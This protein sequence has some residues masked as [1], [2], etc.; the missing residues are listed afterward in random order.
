MKNVLIILL[1]LLAATVLKGQ[2]STRFTNSNV[3]LELGGAGFV[4]ANFEKIFPLNEVARLSGR[5]GLGLFPT[6]LGLFGLI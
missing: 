2:D 4:S 1:V 6:D 5:A 3:F